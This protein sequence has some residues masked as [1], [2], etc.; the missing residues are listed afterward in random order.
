MQNE[1]TQACIG[2]ENSTVCI[3]K[4]KEHLHRIN[5]QSDLISAWSYH[6]T[7]TETW[8]TFGNSHLASM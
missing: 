1:P 7:T 3:L 2:D 6:M 4:Q 5:K 8:T